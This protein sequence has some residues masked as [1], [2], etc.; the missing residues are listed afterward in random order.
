MWIIVGQSTVA[1]KLI[2]EIGG[3]RFAGSLWRRRFAFWMYDRS[4]NTIATM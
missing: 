1:L 2:A 4:K 3:V